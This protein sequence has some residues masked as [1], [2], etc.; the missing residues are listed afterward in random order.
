[1]SALANYKEDLFYQR[2][3]FLEEKGIKEWN[4]CTDEEGDEYIYVDHETDHS[5]TYRIKLEK[6]YLVK[7]F[8]MPS[9][10]SKAHIESIHD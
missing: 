10:L 4:I 1:M 9:Y 3:D 8:G 5:D 2:E 7:D 6:K